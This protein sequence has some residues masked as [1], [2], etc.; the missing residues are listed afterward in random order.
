MGYELDDSVYW[1]FFA[2]TVNYNSSHSELLLNELR[3]LSDE[4]SIKNLS[5]P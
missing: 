2:I 4:S 3:L 1:H 5:L